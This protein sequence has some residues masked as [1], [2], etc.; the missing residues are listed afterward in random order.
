MVLGR[1]AA[2]AV[3]VVVAVADLV[4]L[5]G[6]FGGADLE[7]GGAVMVVLEVG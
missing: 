7:A 4:V 3:D 5:V 1:D 2:E 6:V